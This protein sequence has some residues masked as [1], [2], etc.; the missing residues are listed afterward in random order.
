MS[1]DLGCEDA[2]RV[3]GDSEARI[4]ICGSRQVHGN[5]MPRTFKSRSGVHGQFQSHGS[6]E[7]ARRCGSV[8]MRCGSVIVVL[9]IVGETTGGSMRMR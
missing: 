5:V 9:R 3:S 7:H 8:T 2:C 6:T 1:R 4:E